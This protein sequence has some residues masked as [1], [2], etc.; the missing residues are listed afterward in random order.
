MV[1]FGII[2]GRLKVPNGFILMTREANISRTVFKEAKRCP[3]DALPGDE[4]EI[5]TS[6]CRYF[7][8]R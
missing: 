5:P 2:I 3:Q 8:R 7:Y 4:I 1:N 6:E